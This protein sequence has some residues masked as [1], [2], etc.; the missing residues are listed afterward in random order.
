MGM[1]AG[2]NQPDINVTPL[3][4]VLLVLLIIF[5]VVAP[6]KPAQFETKVPQ[7]N[8]NPTPTEQNNDLLMVVL[9]TNNTIEFPAAQ[10]VTPEEL[11]AKLASALADRPE[12]DRTV[13]IAAPTK[14]PY[15]NIVNVID[16]IKGAGATTIGLQIDSLE[17]V[18][19]S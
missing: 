3:I 9:K 13:I 7:K 18:T 11:S 5:M 16:V 4:D 12:A 8:P 19:Q 10:K 17:A 2:G 1:S 14:L 6:L 15:N